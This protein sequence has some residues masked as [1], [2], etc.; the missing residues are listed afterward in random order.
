MRVFDSLGHVLTSRVA[1]YCF[2]LASTLPLS[3]FTVSQLPLRLQLAYVRLTFCWFIK[4]ANKA[5]IWSF[6][7]KQEV[8][9]FSS[10]GHV[11]GVHLGLHFAD[12]GV[13]NNPPCCSHGR[14]NK[15]SL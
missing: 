7:L 12:S 2:G 11:F 1:M 8:R 4:R 9:V 14:A 13:L 6:P 5:S 3:E 15:T 10:L